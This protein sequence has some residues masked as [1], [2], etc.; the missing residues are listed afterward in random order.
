MN[1]NTQLVLEY[2]GATAAESDISV[3][4]QRKADDQDNTRE[5]QQLHNR[6]ERHCGSVEQLV[7]Q[8]LRLFRE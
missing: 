5:T 1:M 7:S 4:A 8:L 6:A 3:L 2:S